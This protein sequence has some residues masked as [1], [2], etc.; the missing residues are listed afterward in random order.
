MLNSTSDWISNWGYQ[1]GNSKTDLKL[2]QTA[3]YRCNT[4]YQTWGYQTGLCQ[5]GC[6]TADGGC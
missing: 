3:R 6:M 5:S 4:G 2:S 1:A